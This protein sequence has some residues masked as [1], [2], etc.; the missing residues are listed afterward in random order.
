MSIQSVDHESCLLNEPIIV[1]GGRQFLSW[2]MWLLGGVVQ[3]SEIYV[4]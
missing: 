4:G 3:I 2:D 1:G